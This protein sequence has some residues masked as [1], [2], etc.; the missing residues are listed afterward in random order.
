MGK[1][2]GD[3]GGSK[4]GPQFAKTGSFRGGPKFCKTGSRWGF[5]IITPNLGYLR[6]FF[7]FTVIKGQNPCYFLFEIENLCGSH[8]L[9]AFLFM[10]AEKK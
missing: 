5:P 8:I 6:Q 3:G 4:I 1:H 9:G 7:L 10:S 2:L